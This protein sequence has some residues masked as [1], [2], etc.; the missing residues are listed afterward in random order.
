MISNKINSYLY[1]IVEALY[2]FSFTLL[3]L[4]PKLINLQTHI[5]YISI[6]FFL[7]F[8]ILKFSIDDKLFKIKY[9]SYY[10]LYQVQN[11][12]FAIF[13][14]SFG[15]VVIF[16]SLLGFLVFFNILNN[17]R[18]IIIHI[19]LVILIG[20]IFFMFLKSSQFITFI[21]SVPFIFIISTNFNK[22]S[23][24]TND[25]IIELS[26]KDD[27]TGLLNQ[28]G[29]MKKIEEE[30]YRSQRYNNTFSVLMIDSD[31]LKLINDTYGHKYG[32]L[33]I[34]SIAEVIKS[35][36][37]RTDFAAR[38]GGD[39]FI[40]CL[41]ETDIN[42]ANEVAERIIKLPVK[43]EPRNIDAIFENGVCRIEFKRMPKEIVMIKLNDD[44]G[45]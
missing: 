11:I 32:S 1:N 44:G 34:T 37:R 31:N 29:F 22:I 16:L 13:F 8:I 4:S 38:Y 14:Q 27:L 18:I 6:I 20:T 17:K 30:F 21:L 35:N 33:V 39:E 7:I 41:V 43:V 19:V 24:I 9:I 36:I 3:I 5:N 10:F 42:G 45:Q 25:L 2:L 12:F 15:D 26:I 23:T 40:L 28:S